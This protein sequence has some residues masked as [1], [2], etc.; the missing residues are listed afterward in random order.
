MPSLLFIFTA[1]LMTM[2]AACT[3]GLNERITVDGKLLCDVRFADDQ[4]K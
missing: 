1:E 2:E 3:M 4:E